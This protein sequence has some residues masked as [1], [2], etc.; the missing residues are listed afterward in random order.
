MKPISRARRS[1]TVAA[2]AIGKELARLGAPRSPIDPAALRPMKPETRERPFN[3]PGWVFE[4][5]YDGFRMVAAGGEGEARLFYKSGHDATRIFPELAA[6]MAALPFHGV[7]LDGEAVVLDDDGRPSF[8]RLQR[9]GLRTRLADVQH[10]ASVSPATLFV[11]DLLGFEDFDLRPLPLSDRKAILRRVVAP[12]GDWLRLSEEIPERG[13]DLYA[14]VVGMGLE[15]IV[16]K[17]SDAPYRSGYSADWLK[18]RVD[19]SS[20]FV[21]I[22]FEGAS[23]GGSGIRRLH[24]AVVGEEGGLVYAGTVGTGFSRETEAELRAR[25]EPLHRASPPLPMGTLRGAVWVEPEAVVEVRYK[26]WTEGGNLRHPVFLRLRDDKTAA[27]CFRPGEERETE[28]AAAAP[29][30]PA[31]ATPI[32]PAA[33]TNLDKVFWPDLGITKGDLIEYYRAVAPT[34]LPF[35]RDRPLVLDRY[36][37]GIAGKSF[38]QKN[39]PA[40]ASGRLRTLVV[41]SDGAEKEIEYLLCDDVEGLLYLVNLGAIPFHIGASRVDALDRPDWCILDLDPKTAPF[42][43]VVRIALEIREL[44]EEIG[45]PCHVKT[46]GGSGLHILLP[47]GGRLEH[48]P[49]KQLAELLAG[50]IVARL[51][52]I[53]TTARA[54]A[55]R[56]GRVYVDALQNGRGKLLAAPYCARP[57]PAASVSTPLD[58]REVNGRLDVRAFTVKTVPQRLRKRKADPLLPV[59]T[60]EPDLERVIARLSEKL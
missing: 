5:K 45:I 37:D 23:P 17:R 49:V 41:K 19:R 12:G 15:G 22:G 50:V 9:R 46:S 42:A 51:P 14:A 26:E 11:F 30:A 56:R 40:K 47:M 4:L 48:E 18:V 24:L 43:D 36:P 13:E 38:F 59:L 2:R 54:I 57:V 6:A 20:D 28:E 8:Q 16:A 53:A 27:E 35:L 52:A 34:M 44:C 1:A 21:V 7:V 39:A 3:H 32:K 58:W 33:F 31:P 29:P 25:L 10:A 60:E 55:A